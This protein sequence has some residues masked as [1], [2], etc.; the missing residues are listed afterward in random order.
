VPRKLVE[1]RGLAPTDAPTNN[2]FAYSPS[3]DGQRFLVN[4]DSDTAEPQINVITN[5]Q[6]AAAAKEP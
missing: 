5:W 6:K 4:M 1:Y 3:P 2:S